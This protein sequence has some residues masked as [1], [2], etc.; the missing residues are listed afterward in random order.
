MLELLLRVPVCP[1]R[2][3]VDVHRLRVLLELRTR[4]VPRGLR[5]EGVGMGIPELGRVPEKCEAPA[6]VEQEPPSQKLRT[7]LME[8][9]TE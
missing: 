8:A 5:R 9:D 7:V 4:C 2:R 1:V 3:G 6:S